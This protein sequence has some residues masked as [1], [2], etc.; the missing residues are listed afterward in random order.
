ML[1][2]VSPSGM[3]SLEVTQ[4]MVEGAILGTYQF[5]VY[6][7]EAASG[8]D[9]AEMKI[10]IPRKSQLRQAT[11]GIRRGVAAA[12]A[13]VFVRDLCN[14]PSNVLTPTRVADE[15]KTIAKNVG[16]GCVGTTGPI[17][18]FFS[19]RILCA[20]RKETSPSGTG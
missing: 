14:H 1:P 7:S 9:V 4:A 17:G 3:S 11:E 2:T 19:A 18:G 5:T 15:A 20:T 8:Q 12:E 10:L 13:T 16:H 6:R